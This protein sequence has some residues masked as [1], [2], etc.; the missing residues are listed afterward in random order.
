[1]EVG[2][3]HW[4][5]RNRNLAKIRSETNAGRLVIAPYRLMRIN[6]FHCRSNKKAYICGS[7]IK[8]L[9]KGD[10]LLFYR[11]GDKKSIACIGVVEDFLRSDV[12]SEIIPFVARRTV[13]FDEE[14]RDKAAKG[15]QLAIL[16]RV[17]KYL[18]CE[19]K[20]RDLELSG[21]KGAVQSIRALDERIYQK[22]FKHHDEVS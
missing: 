9:N 8:Q 15:E 11:S 16:F 22:L 19:I 3:N 17:V 7:V 1:M 6:I 12:A 21:V 18:R 5:R 4:A 14:I 10:L 13:F 20:W 2:R